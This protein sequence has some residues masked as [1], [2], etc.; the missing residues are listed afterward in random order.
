VAAAAAEFDAAGGTS[1]SGVQTSDHW[2][3]WQG[4]VCAVRGANSTQQLQQPQQQLSHGGGGS[5]N[6]LLDSLSTSVPEVGV[7]AGL[8]WC[9]A[10]GNCSLLALLGQAVLLTYSLIHS[11][12]DSLTH[13]YAKLLCGF[14]CLNPLYAAAAGAVSRH[15]W[16]SACGRRGPPKPWR[17]PRQQRQATQGAQPGCQGASASS[18]GPAELQAPW[19]TSCSSSSRQ[20]C[21]AAEAARRYLT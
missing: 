2:A 14:T 17:A 20:H 13:A 16:F 19:Q 12:T 10:Q 1:S 18:R 21:T 4:V 9:H 6:S 15:P 8:S 7:S 5:T 3:K 11:L